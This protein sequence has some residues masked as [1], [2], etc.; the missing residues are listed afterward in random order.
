MLPTLYRPFHEHRRTLIEPSRRTLREGEHVT[1]KMLIPDATS[2]RVHNGQRVLLTY[3][4][5]N[6]M[7]TKELVVESDVTVYA[8]FDQTETLQGICKFNMT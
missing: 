6:Q 7:L 5:E 4:Y 1:I 2:V 8:I 3:G